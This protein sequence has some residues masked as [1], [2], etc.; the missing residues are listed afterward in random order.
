MAYQS[1][2]LRREF[3]INEL[4]TVHYFEYPLNFAFHGESHDF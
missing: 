2:R 4:V 1:T 3:E